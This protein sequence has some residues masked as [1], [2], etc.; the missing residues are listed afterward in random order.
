M[1]SFSFRVAKYITFLKNPIR[2]PGSI[3]LHFCLPLNAILLR[4]LFCSSQRVMNWRLGIPGI[5]NASLLLYLLLSSLFKRSW[6]Y[7]EFVILRCI[8][9]NYIV[10]SP[11][12]RLQMLV[13]QFYWRSIHKEFVIFQRIVLRVQ[14]RV[15]LE[16]SF[17]VRFAHWARPRIMVKGT[18]KQTKMNNKK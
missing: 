17:P 7:A 2:D 1:L 14:T 16:R 12:D 15:S 10:H 18:N 5:Q 9:V 13:L 6:N 8:P 3:P 4:W 11:E